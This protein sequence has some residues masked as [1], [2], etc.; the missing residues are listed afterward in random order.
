MT[1]APRRLA[2]AWEPS[3]LPLSATMVSPAILC[4]HNARWAF[5]IQRANV[6]DSFK[7]GITMDTSGTACS[8]I[9]V[10]SVIQPSTFTCI[11]YYPHFKIGFVQNAPC[12][13]LY[14]VGRLSDCTCCAVLFSRSRHRCGFFHR[15]SWNI[16]PS[17]SI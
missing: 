17:D 4:S 5:S 8:Y 1:R 15:P 16:E 11:E 9:P 14:K 2:M 10:G 6:S 3:V 13:L 7:Q 12:M